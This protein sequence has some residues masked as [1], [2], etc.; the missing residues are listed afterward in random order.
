[1]VVDMPLVLMFSLRVL[2]WQVGVLFWLLQGAVLSLSLRT[3]DGLDR[4][5]RDVEAEERS[6]MESL[7]AG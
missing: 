2:V 5:G 3:A 4:D 1:M 6:G 7:H